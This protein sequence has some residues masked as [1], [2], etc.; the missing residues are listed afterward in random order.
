MYVRVN[1]IEARSRNHCCHGKAISI[2]YSECISVALVILHSLCMLH[3]VLSSVACPVLPHFPTLSHKRHDF[4]KL[5]IEHVMC[6]LI[7]TTT[8]V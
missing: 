8:F 4:R 6:V 3:I 5:V 2:T 1:D 7:L